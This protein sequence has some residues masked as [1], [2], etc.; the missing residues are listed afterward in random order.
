[1]DLKNKLLNVEEFATAVRLESRYC[2]AEGLAAADR[3]RPDGTL[4]SL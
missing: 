3:V 4:N 2:A 1:M